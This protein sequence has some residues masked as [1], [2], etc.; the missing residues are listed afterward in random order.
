MKIYIKNILGMWALLCADGIGAS[1]MSGFECARYTRP[2]HVW[3]IE[4]DTVRCASSVRW[5][6][7]QCK[8]VCRGTGSVVV[9]ETRNNDR[10]LENSTRLSEVCMGVCVRRDIRHRIINVSLP[11]PLE[12]I[13]FK[14]HIGT[15]EHRIRSPPFLPSY[16]R[17]LQLSREREHEYIAWGGSPFAHLALACMY[18][19]RDTNRMDENT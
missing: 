15:H 6:R 16:M 14:I 10:A 2:S 19:R 8:I 12:K 18:M 7:F 3:K 11:G 17:L 5:R 1:I 13:I 9:T 4:M